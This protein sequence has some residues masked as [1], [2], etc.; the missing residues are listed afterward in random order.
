M[1]IPNLKY[2]TQR[3]IYFQSKL[4]YYFKRKVRQIL[5]QYQLKEE[6]NPYKK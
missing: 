4:E 2:M 5:P 6:N 3:K 1:D